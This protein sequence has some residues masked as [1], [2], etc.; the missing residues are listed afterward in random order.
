MRIE[1]K[2]QYKMD[3]SYLDKNLKLRINEYFNLAQNNATE[4]FKKFDGDNISV[5]KNDNAVW[6][7]AKSKIHIYKNTKWLD[8]IIAES[9]T[10][11]VKPIRVETETKF[12]DSNN[13]LLF[14][15]SQQSCPLDMETRKI[16]KIDTLTFPKDI[17][18]DTT[19]FQNNY[20]K[21]NDIFEE[22]DFV[23]EQKVYSQDIDYS[24]HVNN[25]VYVRYIMNSLSND[26]LDKVNI[27]DAEI[28]YIEE[29]KEGQI[30]K[31]YK[32]ELENNVIRFLIKENDREIIRASIKY[33][34]NNL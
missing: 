30:L 21:L 4:Y 9:Y 28:H 18:I 24:N 8:H 5:R 16:R 27:I 26:F 29:S 3:Y 20:Q 10:S 17:R 11:M 34:K 7:V 1:C 31:I 32:K 13:E 19:L 15:A 22:K 23:Y 12:K 6:V 14:I 25:T 2:N 33:C